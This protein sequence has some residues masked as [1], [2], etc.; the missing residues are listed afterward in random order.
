[1]TRVL[2]E[3][4]YP[5]LWPNAR[6][7]WAVRA[8]ATKGYRFAAKVKC[9]GAAP[10]IVR[11]TFCPKPMGPMPDKDNCIAAFK[12]GQDGI[13]DALKINDRDLTVIHEMG[14]RCK[15][16]G[17]IVEF[18]PLEASIPFRGQIS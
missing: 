8:K 3:W 13:A 16:G 2:L 7:H 11:V 17:V 15:D 14:G 4:P 5:A 12:A 18:L 9:L 10:G 6:A 1:M